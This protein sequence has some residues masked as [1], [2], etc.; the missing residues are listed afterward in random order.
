MS[1]TAH[2]FIEQ[3]RR[4]LKLEYLPKIQACLERLTREQ[5]WWRPAE[6]SNS[7]G[8]LVVHLA[9]NLRQWVVSGVAGAE[10]RRDREAEFAQRDGAAGPELAELLSGVVSEAD[11][12]LAELD[13]DALLEYRTIQNRRVTVLAAV[14]H[15]VEHFSMHTGQITWVTKQ[16]TRSDLGFYDA[17]GMERAWWLPSDQ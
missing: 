16:L 7:V 8:N 11:R 1:H 17:K 4:Y 6:S 15:V 5:I 9:G 12:V 2:I 13:E 14:Y 3:S 10:D